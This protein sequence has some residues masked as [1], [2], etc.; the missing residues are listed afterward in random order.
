[1]SAEHRPG[2][3]ARKSTPVGLIGVTLSEPDD[4]FDRPPMVRP[5]RGRR[6]ATYAAALLLPVSIAVVAHRVSEPEGLDA[7][8]SLR[9]VASADASDPASPMTTRTAVAMPRRAFARG[10]FGHSNAVRIRIVLPNDSIGLP[11]EFSGD[12]EGMQA[13]WIAFDGMGNEAVVPWPASRKMRVP[14]RPGA[15]WL[16]LSRGAVADTVADLAL[17]VEHPMP[18][19]MATGINGY[20]FGRWPRAA[21]GAVPRGFIGVTERIRDF[22]L[23]PHL[24]L[25]DFVVHDQQRGFPKYLHVSEALLD[26]IELTVAEVAQMRGRSPSS[27]VL[28]VASGFRSPAHNNALSGTAQDSRHMYGDAADIAIDANEDGRLTE[29]DARLVASAAEAV[30]RKYP[31]LVGGIG[32]YITTEGAGWPYVHIDVRGNRSRWRSAT[33]RGGRVDWLPMNATFDSV[34]AA[35]A[36]SAPG[37]VAAPARP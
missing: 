36:A 4:G 7:A 19:A 26:K 12:A 20:H 33:K 11:I 5:P 31:D 13:Q 18:N 14:S 23:S 2:G 6:F 17:L 15:F 28:N 37:T 21:D 25:S 35:D 34:S 30:E 8:E 3:A 32:L 24:R 22:P 29:I 1:M 27:V 10:A 9:P 16:V